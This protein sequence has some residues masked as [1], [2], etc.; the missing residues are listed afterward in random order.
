MTPSDKKALSGPS[1]LLMRVFAILPKIINIFKGLSCM[2]YLRQNKYHLRNKMK[3]NNTKG[4]TLIELLVVIAIIGLLSSVVLVAVYN[5]RAKSR[6]AK[7]VSDMTRMVTGFELFNATYRGYPTASS[8]VPNDMVPNFI[9]SFPT[10]PDPADGTCAATNPSTGQPANTYY[11]V[12][13]G[14]TS[15]VSGVTVYSDYAYYFCIGR[16]TGDVEAGIHYL[17]PRGILP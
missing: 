10:S 15:V 7:R 13:T 6:D 17:T 3:T 4:F 9:A 2:V 8:G 5:A 1:M 14:T 11:Y 12:P 16:Q